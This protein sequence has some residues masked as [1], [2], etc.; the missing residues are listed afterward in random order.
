GNHP[1]TFNTPHIPSPRTWDPAFRFRVARVTSAL[2]AILGRR[3]SGFL[4]KFCLAM[5]AIPSVLFT[6][7][8][9]VTD[10]TD[11]RLC[12]PLP[13]TLYCISPVFWIIPFDRRL[14]RPSAWTSVTPT[15]LPA[16]Y[17]SVVA[18][19]CLF[20]S[21]LSNKRLLMDPTPPDSFMSTLHI[22]IH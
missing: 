12:E 3:S 6:D 20:N 7:C 5:L 1:R 2:S 19:L 18:E 21:S 15:D 10:W 16:P 14:P 11:Y 4:A 9:L 13:P 17:Q 8:L 22:F